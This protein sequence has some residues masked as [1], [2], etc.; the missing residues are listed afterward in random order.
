LPEITPFLAFNF[1]PLG[2]PFAA[3]D[4][5]PKLV[6]IVKRGMSFFM[7]TD[8]VDK[9]LV[10]LTGGGA[11]VSVAALLLTLPAVLNTVTV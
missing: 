3:N 5:A 1:S 11:T 9:S 2:R 10:M 6:V 7:G 4:L 8:T